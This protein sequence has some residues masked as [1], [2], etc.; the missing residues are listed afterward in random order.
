MTENAATFENDEAVIESPSEQVESDEETGASIE[1]TAASLS[2]HGID[3]R[4]V[5]E[6]V[7]Y[8]ADAKKAED[9]QVLDLTELSDVCDYFV[10]ATGSNSRLVDAIVDEIE[11]KVGEKCH[12]KP[13]SIEGRD[14][15]D[16]ILMD[17][18]AVVVHVFTPDARDYYRLERLW[19]DAPRI[20][21]ALQG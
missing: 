8:A 12:E 19:G 16:W 9:V 7:A 10:I 17:Y 3:G 20:E 1:R 5:A 14:R 6:A 4:A 21:L 11:E 15:R 13:F 18:G 2:S